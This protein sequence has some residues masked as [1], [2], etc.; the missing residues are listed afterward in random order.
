MDLQELIK[1]LASPIAGLIC[2]IAGVVALFRGLKADGVIDLAMLIKGKVTMGIAGILLLVF[3][4]V[5]ITA[6][7]IPKKDTNRAMFTLPNGKKG[8]IVLI[9]HSKRSS[10]GEIDKF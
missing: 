3:G 7:V 2:I 4:T 6:L 5:M 8:Y 9:G 10:G 1:M